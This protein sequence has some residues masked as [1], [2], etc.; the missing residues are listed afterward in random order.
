[1]TG[2]NSRA[3]ISVDGDEVL[4]AGQAT[5]SDRRVRLFFRSV[6]GAIPTEDGW[7]CP[8]R[9]ASMSS[10]IVRIN[11]FLERQG[12][13]LT[14][15][16]LADREVERELERL[17]SF[18]RTQETATDWKAGATVIDLK[19]VQRR[20]TDFGWTGARV[21]RPHQEQG[22]AHALAAANAA[23]FSVPGSGKTATALAVAASHLVA[24]TIDLVL[25]VGPLS[26]F[27]PW[28]QE[29]AIA[30]GARLPTRRVR[31]N[32]QARR[33]AYATAS[34]GSVLLVSFASAAADR[35]ALTEMCRARNVMLIVDESHRIKRFRG[36]L[37]APALVQIA[38]HARVR[39]ILSGTPMPQSGRDLYSQLNILWPGGELTGPRD[40][41]AA[42]VDSDF[43][44]V[45]RAVHPFVARTPKSA[46]GL[47]PYEVTR[48]AVPLSG[49][50]AEIYDLVLNGFRR[51]VQDTETWADKIESLRRARPIRLLQA[52]TNP[53]LFNRVDSYYRL[54]RVDAAS[55]TLM[56]RLATY[57][58]REVPGKSEVALHILSEIAA[59]GGK[60]VCWSNFIG[61]L[62]QFADLVRTRL[63]LPCF[64]IDGRVPAG[65]E[66][67]DDGHTAPRSNPDDVDTRERIIERFLGTQG[68]AVLVTNPATCSES[69][70]LHRGCHHAIYLDRT[71]DC[72]QFLQ[73]IDRIHRLGLTPGVTVQ[74]HI[75]LAT[76]NAGP[77]VDHLV[78]A[79]LLN[80]E[81]VM[82]ELLEG[83]ELHPLAQSSNP[84]DD[85][86]GTEQD[87]ASL[88]RY[89][90]GEE[91]TG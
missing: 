74:V 61:N 23:N 88:L 86:E 60:T 72:A 19:D 82:R 75:L 62:D 78:D 46:L 4:V 79:S 53:D 37:W 26:C 38:G 63:G 49:T 15:H 45:L 1:M 22:L 40:G 83:A 17:R 31:G 57:A 3:E 64:Q 84:A 2:A 71:Y 39:M 36:G 27:G 66:P 8:R 20:L 43:G 73:S 30:L 41:F 9:H 59:Q 91:Q 69:I 7:R 32:V 48:H 44:S 68:P 90:L 89:M 24:E 25:V 58:E 14:R 52:A 87:L 51:R 35:L 54:P 11:T 21:L 10:L 81:A 65:D 6:L 34:P 47:T 70:S 16:G 5:Q 67:V 33:A 80:K 29:A 77:T 50:Q 76:V 55:P 28:E 13:N 85:A 42:R 18:T 56:D 12:F